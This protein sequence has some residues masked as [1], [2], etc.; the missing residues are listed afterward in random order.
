MGN[1]L[2]KL[3]LD[4]SW[5]SVQECSSYLKLNIISPARMHPSL[6]KET[7]PCR[8]MSRLIFLLS[9]KTYSNGASEKFV[10]LVVGRQA[11]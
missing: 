6:L 7:I 3:Q 4:L 10:T 5:L 1:D 2:E 9:I 11:N 8:K